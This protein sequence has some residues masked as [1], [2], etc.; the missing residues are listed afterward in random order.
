MSIEKLLLMVG[1]LQQ[2]V[3]TEDRKTV[4]DEIAVSELRS[5]LQVSLLAYIICRLGV[6]TCFTAH[7]LS[8]G[9]PVIIRRFFSSIDISQTLNIFM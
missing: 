7:F 8:D 1:D 4:V 6:K 3:S 9:A 2:P 5:L